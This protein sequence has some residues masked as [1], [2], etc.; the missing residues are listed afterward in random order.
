MKNEK[1]TKFMAVPQCPANKLDIVTEIF[2]CY[3]E[4][5]STIEVEPVIF[6]VKGHI[7][8]DRVMDFYRAIERIDE[9]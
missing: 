6:R 8:K 9:D 1:I 4:D 2:K 3:A 5:E 7:K